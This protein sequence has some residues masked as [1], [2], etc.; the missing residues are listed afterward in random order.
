MIVK[1]KKIGKSFGFIGLYL[2]LK[3]VASGIYVVIRGKGL[4]FENI[5]LL[6]GDALVL[7]ILAFLKR[8]KLKEDFAKFKSDYKDD[9]TLAFKY[10]CAGFVAMLISNVAVILI[11]G[12]I[13]PNEEANR[14]FL[15][16]YPFYSV[17]A[18]P[19]LAPLTEEMVFRL[20]FKETFTK[21][22][23]FVL[24]TGIIFGFMHVVLSATTLKD[25]LYILPYSALGIAFGWAYYDSDNIW[26]SIIMHVFHNT[27]T[28]FILFTGM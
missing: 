8:K 22:V 6:A 2:L 20:N 1:I 14:E 11:L 15:E 18:I 4:I 24:A 27:L 19:V 28:V 23:P 5:V 13:A 9:L 16:M 26:T 7:G 10:W 17:L 25:F 12:G 21:R 3:I